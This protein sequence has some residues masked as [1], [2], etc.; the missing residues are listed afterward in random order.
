[1][2]DL[3]SIRDQAPMPRSRGRAS[4]WPDLIMQG[5]DGRFARGKEGGLVEL[6]R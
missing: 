3:L 4:P 6:A 1:M 5:R 2:G